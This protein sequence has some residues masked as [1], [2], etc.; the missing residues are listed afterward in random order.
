[1]LGRIVVTALIA[2]AVAGVFAWGAHMVKAVPLIL[3][4]EVYEDAAG[5]DEHADAGGQAGA[6][7]DDAGAGQEWTPAEGFE[8]SLYTLL[9]DVIVAIG[10]AFLLSAAF[11]L[12]QRAIGWQRGIIWGLAGFAAFY[13]SPALGLAPELPGMQAAALQARQVWWIAAAAAAAAG[14]GL[15]FFARP[16]WAKVAGA[17]LIVVPHLFGAPVHEVHSGALPAELAAEF[18]VVTLVTTGLFWMLL[19]GLA[20]YLYDRL[21]RA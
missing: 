19:G 14:L 9:A 11:A 13:V 1:M 5:A 4:A 17:G 8:R 16:S 6:E 2:G 20:G 12:S 15:V 18:V 10:F 21:G 7:A 3:A